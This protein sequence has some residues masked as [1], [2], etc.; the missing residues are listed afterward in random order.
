MNNT[1]NKI[2]FMRI[3]QISLSDGS[4]VPSIGLGTFGSDSVDHETVANT[5][6]KAI[7]SGYRHI[8]CAS[9]YGNEAHIGRVLNDL[10]SSNFIKR[11][12]LWITS[13]VWNNMHG[14]VAE[15]CKKTL[16][17]LQI[18]YLDLYLVHWPFPNFHPPKCDVS[19][20]NP[21]A[22]PYIHENYMKTWQQMENL[23]DEG[24]VR[25]IGTSNM[26]I[27]KL[28]LLLRDAR[29]K[30]AFN[31]ME[32]HPHFQQP[33]LSEFCKSNNIQPI[34]YCPLGSPGRPDRDRTPDD[35]VDLEDRVIVN[36]ATRL[37][38]SPAQVAI[39]WAIQ[40]GQIPIPFSV[41][42][43]FDN[44]EASVS[45]EL[46]EADMEAISEIDKGCRLI[47]GQVFLW[48]DSQSWEDLWD[49]NGEIIQ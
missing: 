11:E 15:S 33:E 37:Q 10:F 12:D 22:K 47:K 23:V 29:I 27:P 13:K 43:F 6:K 20:R 18:D 42:H 4:K 5:V 30:P 36:I 46:T 44:L 2:D 16:A 8:D 35:T 45:V 41:N 7:Y 14:R 21:D 28:K 49:L 32:L 9:V 3:P 19:S 24:L 17:D 1:G 40:R 31:E 26:T 38:V 25:Y 48:K 39:K 34:A